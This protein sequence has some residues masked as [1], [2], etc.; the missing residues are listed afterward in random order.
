MS[1]QRLVVQT[2]VA[3]INISLKLAGNVALT[4]GI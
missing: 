3:D 1:L 2:I 4:I